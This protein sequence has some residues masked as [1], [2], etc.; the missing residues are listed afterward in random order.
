MSRRRKQEVENMQQASR[1]VLAMPGTRRLRLGN[2]REL[3]IRR[4]DWVGFELLWQEFCTLISGLSTGSLEDGD[5]LLE[6]LGA[7]PQ[8]VL[9][10]AAL[11]S[12][13]AGEQL[14]QWEH[15]CV[16]ELAT[17]ALEFNFAE[18]Q[19]LRDFS[20]ALARLWKAAQA[21]AVGLPQAEPDGN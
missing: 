7:A 20:S 21:E 14:A 4:L 1:S 12:G 10:L 15:G 13:I 16:L 11:S 2:G 8:L 9:K 6:Q 3:E 5:A 17:A 19:A 18:G